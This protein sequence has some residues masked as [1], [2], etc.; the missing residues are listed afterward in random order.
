MCNEFQADH[1]NLDSQNLGDLYNFIK[2]RLSRAGIEN[3]AFEARFIIENRTALDWSS[4]IA[5]PEIIIK[6]PLIALINEDI[7]KRL[8]GIPLHRI[9]GKREFWGLDFEINSSTLDPRADTETLV[10]IALAVSRKNKPASILDIG[11][12]SGCILISLLKELPGTSGV[13]VD[14][15]F[16]AVAC[17]MKNAKN[18]G[19]GSNVGFFCGSWLDAIKGQFDLIVSNPPYICSSVIPNLEKEVREHDPILAL[20]GGADGLQAY[21][22]IFSSLKNILSK[23]GVALF[24]IGYDQEKSIM[25]LADKYRLCAKHPHRDIAGRARVVE[26]SC[27]DK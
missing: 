18:H 25:R 19:I 16:D 22:E 10:E 15:S 13:G 2:K 4:I 1:N 6:R 24:E 11:T 3:S 17:A 27:G 23:D 8:A 9:Y 14:L 21:C 7:K 20:D 26:I 12:G 5:K